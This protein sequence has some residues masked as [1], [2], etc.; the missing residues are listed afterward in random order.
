M[1]T[2]IYV[3]AQPYVHRHTC[4]A[5]RTS[6]YIRVELH[7]VRTQL[8]VQ[9]H[10]YTCT[11][12]HTH[13]YAHALA[14]CR[15]SLCAGTRYVQALAMYRHSPCAGT[16]L[17]S[18][19]SWNGLH[20]Q[21]G[22]HGLHGVHGPHSLHSPCSLCSPYTIYTACTSYIACAAYCCTAQIAQP[23]QARSQVFCHRA[24]HCIGVA[25]S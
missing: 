8:Y 15:H 5:T 23:G 17:Y 11:A 21:H 7:G 18:R 24:T 10:S 2:Y 25:F 20:S 9:L 3:R 19:T 6:V 12:V 16:R 1:H 4:T 13:R 22:V 14:M